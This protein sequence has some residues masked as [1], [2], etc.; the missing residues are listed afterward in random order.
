MPDQ[1]WTHVSMDFIE[2]LPTAQG[3]NVISVVVDRFTKYSH[4]IALSHPYKTQDVVNP[5]LDNV[6]K[7][8]GMP[9]VIV[10]DKGPIFTHVLCGKD[11][12]K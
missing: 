11:F 4:F 6:F 3:K 2:G 7:L 12:S 1:A 5:Y 8:H 9:K 10:T